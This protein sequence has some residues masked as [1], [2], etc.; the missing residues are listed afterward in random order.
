MTLATHAQ[1]IRSVNVVEPY[2]WEARYA[3]GRLR[4]KDWDGWHTSREIDRKR[5]RAFVIHGHPASPIEIGLPYPPW[6]E[7]PAPLE[8]IIQATTDIRE[9]VEVGTGETTREIVT[10]CFFGLRY[11]PDEA[12]IL[13]F[14]PAGHLLAV[15]LDVVQPVECPRC[16]PQPGARAGLLVPLP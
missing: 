10:W 9:T 5:L 13:Q 7:G 6:P 12:H 2:L 3:K 14:D 1:R 11:R 8:V 16:G 4:Q 15:I